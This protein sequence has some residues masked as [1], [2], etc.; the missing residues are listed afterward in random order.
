MRPSTAAGRNRRWRRKSRRRRPSLPSFPSRTS[1]VIPRTRAFGQGLIE[2]DET[3][4]ETIM[5]NDFTSYLPDDI[6]VK[7][8]RASMLTSLEIRAPFLDPAVIEFAFA[9]V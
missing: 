1:R 4:I 6:L 3:P 7:V 2:D 8:D 9:S 5:L